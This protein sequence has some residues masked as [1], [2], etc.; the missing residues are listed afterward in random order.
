M[1]EEE[2][3][4]GFAK[5]QSDA[6]GEVPEPKTWPFYQMKRISTILDIVKITSGNEPGKETKSTPTQ[7]E[8]WLK[9]HGGL[10]IGQADVIHT[11]QA[12]AE[13]VDYK[14]GR[15]FDSEESSNG[16][17]TLKPAYKRQLLIY[18]DLYH[19]VHGE[20]PIRA[21]I[22]SLHDGSYSI[23]PDPVEAEKIASEA[24]ELLERFN[25]QASTGL[26]EASPSEEGCLYCPFK[27]VCTDY[28]EH[29]DVAWQSTSTTIRGWVAKIDEAGRWI[30]L[31]DVSGNTE[32][33]EATVIQVPSPLVDS[34]EVGE[35]L[36]FSGLSGRENKE[37]LDFRWWSQMWK[38]PR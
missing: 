16:E 29:S 26:V 20:W 8:V 4:I 30:R 22:S 33:M 24:I 12:G 31:T 28:L 17:T 25:Q 14:T 21:T 37:S 36:S 2:V 23:V 38:W 10:M 5:M 35:L 13:I 1:W 19:E 3:A 15:I 6:A 27:A 9:G 7:A 18:S 34:A 32:R 11:S